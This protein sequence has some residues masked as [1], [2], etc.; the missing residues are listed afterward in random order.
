MNVPVIHAS[1]AGP[2]EGYESPELPDVPCRSVYLGE[3]MI[4]DSTGQILAR[5]SMHEGA[6]VVLAEFAVTEDQ[7][8]ARA[9]VLLPLPDASVFGTRM[10]IMDSTPSNCS[11]MARCMS[12]LVSDS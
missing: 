11:Y 9:G 4:T 7:R 5:R 10:S 3:A 1:H 12:W 2:F 8:L 6:G